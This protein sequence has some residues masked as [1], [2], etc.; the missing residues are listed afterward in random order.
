[1]NEE[2]LLRVFESEGHGRRYGYTTYH[3]HEVFQLTEIGDAD[4]V[5]TSCGSIRTARQYFNETI[6]WAKIIHIPYRIIR[7]HEH[8]LINGIDVYFMTYERYAGGSRLGAW[9]DGRKPHYLIEDY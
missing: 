6:E 5:F 1:M 2:W 3:I 9:R 4:I 8:L 7:P